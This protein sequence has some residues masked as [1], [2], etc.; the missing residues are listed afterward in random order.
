MPH[1]SWLQAA[2]TA[3]SGAAFKARSLTR[4]RSSEVQHELRQ[5]HE[6][7][8]EH[9]QGAQ[10]SQ[11]LL[12]IRHRIWALA[13]CGCTCLPGAVLEHPSLVARPSRPIHAG[14]HQGT[15]RRGTHGEGI[16]AYKCRKSDVTNRRCGLVIADI[17]RWN[18]RSG[19]RS[20]FERN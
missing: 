15:D 3:R 19:T 11:Q 7:H 2:A 6:A 9:T 10:A 12:R 14:V 8:A 13:S 18:T 16:R 4:P 17:D 20:A 1:I 5:G